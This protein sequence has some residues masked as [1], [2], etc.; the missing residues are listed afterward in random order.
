MEKTHLKYSL[1]RMFL[2]SSEEF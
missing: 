1:L 2:E